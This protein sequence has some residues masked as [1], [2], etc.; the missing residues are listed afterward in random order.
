MAVGWFYL[1][2]LALF[3][4]G[5][6]CILSTIYWMRYW[7]EGFAWDGTILTFN[8]HPVLMVTGM[9]VLYSAAGWASPPSSSS[10]ASGSWALWSFCCP[11][12]LCGCA[13][14]LNPSTSSLEPPFSL[15]PLRLS[16]PASM[17]SSSSVCECDGAG[18]EGKDWGLLP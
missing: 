9:V 3:S 8:W 15:W 10:P 11:G 4:L 6:M 18:V 12:R 14:S 17:R 13:A 1:S 2:A 5:S 7:H 16:F